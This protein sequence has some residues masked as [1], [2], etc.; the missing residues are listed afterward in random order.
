MSVD[1][2]GPDHPDFT[3]FVVLFEAY[4]VHYGQSADPDRAGGWLR[5][6]LS[7]GRLIGFL[8]DGAGLCLVAPC[9]ASL[10]LREFWFIRDLYVAPDQRRRGVARQLLAAVRAGAVAAGAIRLSV[11]TEVDNH[12]AR[13]LYRAAGFAPVTGLDHLMLPL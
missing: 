7:R 13:E 1:R 10:T 2:V 12:R 5:D 9:P 4:R 6:G 11:Q 8:A 3:T